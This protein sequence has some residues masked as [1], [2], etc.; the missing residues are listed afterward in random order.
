MGQETGNEEPLS[1]EEEF[2]RTVRLIDLYIRQKTDLYIQHYVMDPVDFLIKQL[3]YMS[4]LAALLVAGTISAVVGAMLFISTLM[5]LWAALLI[6]GII[7]FVVAGI[8]AYVLFS[9]KLVMKTQT[10]TEM[11]ESGNA[12]AH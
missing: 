7:A 8:I 4:V 1:V 6:I 2:S 12:K 9:R 10:A 11:M 3:M 5:P